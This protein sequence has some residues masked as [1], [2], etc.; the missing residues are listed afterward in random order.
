M[1]LLPAYGMTCWVA[2]DEPRRRLELEPAAAVP[3]LR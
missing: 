3:D 2:F 1:S